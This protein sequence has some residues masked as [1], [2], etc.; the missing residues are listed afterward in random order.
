[1]S[2]K[3]PKVTNQTAQPIN[4]Q[5]TPT[6][7]VTPETNQSETNTSSQASSASAESS[8]EG[9]NLRYSDEDL[10]MFRE[11]IEKKLEQAREELKSLKEALDNHNESLLGNKSWNPEEASDTTEMEYLMNQIS[12]QHQYIKNL[13]A[14]LVRIE[15]KTYGICRVT[16]KLIP[17]ERLKLV[18]HATLSVEAKL[19]RKPEEA[20]TLA[21]PS[22]IDELPGFGDE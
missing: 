14:A 10:K 17:K 1:M 6:P 20:P 5:N 13:E 3:L 21:G 15:N 9:P 16:G 11:L 12:R 18:P 8:T 2:K 19:N 7:A 22:P 4:E